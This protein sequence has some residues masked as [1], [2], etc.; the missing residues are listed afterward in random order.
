MKCGRLWRNFDSNKKELAFETFK[1]VFVTRVKRINMETV[2]RL[3]VYVCV[4]L[5]MFFFAFM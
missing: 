4:N 2:R 5:I 1:R 3:C